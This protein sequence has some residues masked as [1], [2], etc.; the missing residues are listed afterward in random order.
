M[1]LTADQLKAAFAKRAQGNSGSE[2][3]GF[4]D[5]FYP[6][7]KMG[8]GDIAHFRFLPDLDEENPWGFV[9][10]NR[11]HELM[12]NGKKKKLACLEMHGEEC[13][14]CQLSREYYD[15]GDEKMGKAFWRKIEY[16]AQGLVNSSPFEYP[17]KQGENPVRLISIGPKLFKKI[18]A[19]IVSGEFDKPF[20]DLMEGCDFKIMKTQQGEYA[21]YSNSEFGR[22]ITAVSDAQLQFMQLYNLKDYRY[23]KVEREQMDVQI[24]AFLTGKS[25]DD[26]AAAPAAG[27]ALNTAVPTIAAAA[28]VAVTP[29]P[30]PVAAPVVAAPAPAAEAAAPAAAPAEASAGGSSRAQEILERLRRNKPAA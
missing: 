21:D 13:P 2:N 29:A 10:E 19:A 5:K 22:K 26:K 7:Y 4:W 1:A 25:Y 20:Y 14:C 9:V 8:F 23:A 3:T 18:E 30:A 15:A 27:P 17:V 16:V 12:I 28:P 24:Q 6:F 11:Y